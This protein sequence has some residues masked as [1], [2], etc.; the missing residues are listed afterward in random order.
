MQCRWAEAWPPPSQRWGER[1]KLLPAC[2]NVVTLQ[3]PGLCSATL[4]RVARVYPALLPTCMLSR[5]FYII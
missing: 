5:Y 4:Q 2:V 3:L 1:P